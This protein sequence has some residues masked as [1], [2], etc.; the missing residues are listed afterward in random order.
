MDDVPFLDEIVKVAHSPASSS[1]SKMLK[2]FWN[3][4]FI[5]GPDI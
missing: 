3:S 5:F 1:S 2:I 4:A